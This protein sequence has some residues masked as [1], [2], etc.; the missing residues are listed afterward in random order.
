M[1]SN[2]RQA[3]AAFR[4][5]FLTRTPMTYAWQPTAEGYRYWVDDVPVSEAVYE[6]ATGRKD[7]ERARD[8]WL[9]ETHDAW[10]AVA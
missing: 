10:H 8:L 9:L 5:G 4:A 7:L 6:L 3:V 1:Q 2:W